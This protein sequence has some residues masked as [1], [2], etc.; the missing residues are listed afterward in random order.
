[1]RQSAGEYVRCRHVEER[2]F[3]ATVAELVEQFR[4]RVLDGD[5]LTSAQGDVLPGV[6]KGLRWDG[7]DRHS[8]VGALVGV[9]VAKRHGEEIIHAYIVAPQPPGESGRPTWLIMP[10][11]F[12]GQN[13]LKITQETKISVTGC[14]RKAKRVGHKETHAKRAKKKR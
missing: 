3:E 5:D 4:E 7:R 10:T 13:G 2:H 12:V 14:G 9:H 8:V 1:M 6:L 11:E